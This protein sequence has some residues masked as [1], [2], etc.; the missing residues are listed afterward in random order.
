MKTLSAQV[1]DLLLQEINELAK[2]QGASVDHLVSLVLAAQVAAW[3]TRE[4]IASRASRVD[5]KHV[6]EIFSR[7]PD[8]PPLT[9]DE[10][11]KQ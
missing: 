8:A 11:P 1:P 5:W 4:S 3:R 6:D 9:G 7:V 10:L 2:S